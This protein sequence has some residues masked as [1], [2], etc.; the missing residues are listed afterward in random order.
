MLGPEQYAVYRTVIKHVL[1]DSERLPS[2]PTITLRVRKA[3]SEPTTDAQSLSVLIG[4]DPA[5][6]A[7]LIKS[8]SSPLYRRAVAPK[9][10]TEVIALLGFA[11]VHNMVMVHSMR[12]L[13]VFRSEVMKT[14][15]RHSWQ[16]LVI[17]AS[18]ASFF[19]RR[20]NFSAIDEAQMATFLTE[21]GSLAV[22]SALSE[23]QQPP[24]P[25][26]YFTLC[27]HY[28][29]SLGVV[30]LNKWGVDKEFVD[31]LRQSGRWEHTTG[32]ELALI[33]IVNLSIYYAVLFT[34]KHADLP[35][36]EALAAF[37]KLPEKYRKCSKPNYLELI[38]SSTEEI[39][40]IVNTFK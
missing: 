8:A 16:R 2:L 4:K 23:T 21:V 26:T 1:S 36:L 32:D 28:S 20:L 25:D 19:A 22:L 29:K 9:T 6:S 13:F 33:D 35:P 30:L 39:Q 31:V 5:L 40:N 27:R 7:L 24:A 12:N 38:T 17:K 37:A 34:N 10:L 18:L 14:L 15:F 3:L 11:N